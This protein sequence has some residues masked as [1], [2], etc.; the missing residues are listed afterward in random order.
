MRRL[1]PSLDCM[2]VAFAVQGR[3]SEHCYTLV[4]WLFS[5]EWGFYADL[6]SAPPTSVSFIEY[7]H[8]AA[9]PF[10]LHLNE[11]KRPL[12]RMVLLEYLLQDLKS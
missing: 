1:L 6:L 5:Q 8:S 2:Y 7:G 10:L 4:Q 9:P 12:T 3:L 11:S